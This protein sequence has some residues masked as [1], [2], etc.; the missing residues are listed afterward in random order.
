MQTLI[1]AAACLVNPQG[2]LLL[3][4]KRG[5]TCFMLP[6]GKREP[7]ETP[8]QT[9][10]RE[11]NEELLLELPD[12]AFSHLGRFNAAAANEPDTQIES[13]IF[14][15]A[16]D[17]CVNPAAELEALHWYHPDQPDPLNLAPLLTKHVLPRL[18]LGYDKHQ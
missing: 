5:T 2:Q 8:L 11:L 18:F 10:R 15:A 17:Q 9:L 12:S 13:E 1:I 14:T 7:N 3:V 16:L 4:R 6:G